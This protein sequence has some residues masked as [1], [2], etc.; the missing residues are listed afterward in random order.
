MEA[1]TGTAG[2]LQVTAESSE[3]QKSSAAFQ[4]ST[5]QDAEAAARSKQADQ[6]F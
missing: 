1:T 2:Q 3:A 5:Q 4:E 6:R